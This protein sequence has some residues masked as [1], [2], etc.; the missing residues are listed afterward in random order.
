MDHK[1]PIKAIK[2]FALSLL[3]R[4]VSFR[5]LFYAAVFVYRSDGLGAGHL[6]ITVGTGTGH[7]LTKNL[8]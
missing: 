4:S 6:T 3:G 1:R 5:D 8:R 2:S 7:F